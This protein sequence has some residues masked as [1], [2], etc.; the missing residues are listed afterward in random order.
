MLRTLGQEEKET[1]HKF[2]CRAIALRKGS[3]DHIDLVLIQN[4]CWK[5][6]VLLL[7]GKVNVYLVNVR[8]I[9]VGNLGATMVV[10]SG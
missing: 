10:R 4:I 5:R 6:S 9:K 8:S 7:P 3:H 2:C 1:A